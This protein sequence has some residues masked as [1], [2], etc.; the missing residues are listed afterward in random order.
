MEIVDELSSVVKVCMW[1]LRLFIFSF[2]FKFCK[3]LAH[4]QEKNLFFKNSF[5][6]SCVFCPCPSIK[7]PPVSLAVGTKVFIFLYFICIYFMLI[8]CKSKLHYEASVPVC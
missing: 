3:Y 8:L 1:H 4:T 2:F 5:L 6:F 7:K